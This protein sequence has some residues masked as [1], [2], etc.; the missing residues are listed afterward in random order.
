MTSAAFGRFPVVITSHRVLGVG[1]DKTTRSNGP[2]PRRSAYAIRPVTPVQRC[3]RQIKEGGSLSL[4][5]NDPRA[6]YLPLPTQWS[7]GYITEERH[8]VSALSPSRR[9]CLIWL[10]SANVSSRLLGPSL[11]RPSAHCS[12]V[13]ATSRAGYVTTSRW[14]IPGSPGVAVQPTQCPAV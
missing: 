3:R 4:R 5:T 7:R 1:H 10:P 12:W 11:R 6:M 14:S 13:H 8:I 9:R 2:K